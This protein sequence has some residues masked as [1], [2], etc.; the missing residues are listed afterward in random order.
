M[1][2]NQ[3]F[4]PGEL[5]RGKAQISRQSHRCEPKLSR[6]ILAI[7]VDMRRLIGFM[8]VKVES[9][10]AA[11][12]HSWHEGILQEGAIEVILRF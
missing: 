11:P 12:E 1:P 2:L 6:E 4:Y 9:V 8:T 7:N 5:L 10:R 3:G